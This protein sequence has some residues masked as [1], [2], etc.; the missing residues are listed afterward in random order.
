MALFAHVTK[1][2]SGAYGARHTRVRPSDVR[3]AVCISRRRNSG[4]KAEQVKYHET[5][6]LQFPSPFS[7]LALVHTLLKER[8]RS[9]ST[10]NT[11]RQA[12]LMV[13][14]CT[15]HLSYP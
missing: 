6:P 10:L 5:E 11:R 2:G 1:L 8:G 13:S 3:H 4:Y 7:P 14:C 15:L 12:N 9:A